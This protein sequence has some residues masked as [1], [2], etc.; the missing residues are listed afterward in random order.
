MQYGE[1]LVDGR[2]AKKCPCGCRYEI[3]TRRHLNIFE[4]D[5]IN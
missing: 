5:R 3:A 1:E 4:S 2:T